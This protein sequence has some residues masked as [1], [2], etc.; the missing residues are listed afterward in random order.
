[1]LGDQ[2][3][4]PGD[5]LQA[6]RQPDPR[7]P[8][9][10]SSSSSTSWWSSAQS[11]P[12]NSTR[13]NSS[14]SVRQNH[15]TR[16]HLH[17]N[18]QV[19]THGQARHPI[20]SPIAGE[21]AGARSVSRPPKGPGR[22]SADLPAAAAAEPLI[23]ARLISLGPTAGKWRL[24]TPAKPWIVKSRVTSSNQGPQVYQDVATLSRSERF[25]VPL[26]D[27]PAAMDGGAGMSVRH[28][29]LRVGVRV[30][31]G[32]RQ[33]TPHSEVLLRSSPTR[34]HQRPGRVQLERAP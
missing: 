1:M 3:V 30:G 12:M 2:R 22:A 7:E 17:P 18:D 6:L 16:R 11:S 26:D 21:P 5:A 31:A 14:M 27:Q 10:P 33:A 4:Q 34:R 15:S 8:R 19:L 32:P 29:N 28:E 23:D 13:T 24:Q 20:S 25:K 9:P